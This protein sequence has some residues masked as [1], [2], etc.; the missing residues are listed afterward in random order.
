MEQMLIHCTEGEYSE[1]RTSD[2]DIQ[3]RNKGC[4]VLD[5]KLKK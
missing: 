1:L 5:V 3:F 2:V 4:L